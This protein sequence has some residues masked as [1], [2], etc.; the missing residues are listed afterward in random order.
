MSTRS[1]SCCLLDACFVC[2]NGFLR[3]FHVEI[4]A[5]QVKFHWARGG[6]LLFFVLS[7]PP[8]KGKRRGGGGVRFKMV[9]H[10]GGFF[11]SDF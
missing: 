6:S 2:E 5:R 11:E 4:M 10:G 3:Y 9:G 8:K 7:T 1:T